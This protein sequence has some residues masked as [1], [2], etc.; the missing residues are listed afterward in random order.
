MAFICLLVMASWTQTILTTDAELISIESKH[1]QSFLIHK[2]QFRCVKRINASDWNYETHG[3]QWCPPTW[4]EVLC[5]DKAPAGQAV[6]QRCPNY[7]SGFDTDHHAERRCTENGT[8]W[9]NPSINKTWT[10]F[11]QCS[12]TRDIDLMGSM[13]GANRL[14]MLYTVGYGIS[15]GSLIIA[16][17]IMLCCRRLNSKSNTLHIN[18]FFAFILRASVSFLKGAL[19]VRQV[20]LEKD[21]REN[22]DGILEFVD[23]PH[24]ECRLLVTIF[25]YSICVSQLWIF[26]E[27]LYLHNLIYRTLSTERRGVKPYIFLGWLLPFTF[28]IPWVIV[29]Y[30]LDNHHCWTY[31]KRKELFWVIHGPLLA[32][33]VIN[34]IFFMDILRVLCTRVR[35]S[36]RHMGR[37]KYRRLAKFVLVLIPL[38]GVLYIAFHVAF[39]A[40]FKS[41]VGLTH[42][43][44]EMTYNSLQGFILALLFCFLNEEVHAE[45]KRMWYRRKSR[46][47]DSVALTKSFVVSSFKRASYINRGQVRKNGTI[48]PTEVPKNDDILTKLRTRALRIFRKQESTDEGEI[49]ELQSVGESKVAKDKN[50][51]RAES[52]A[53][54]DS[55]DRVS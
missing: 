46:R 19:F 26:M 22:E 10:N 24:W 30:T 18:L 54:A 23:G 12:P 7:I 36:A 5:W 53:C 33:V 6:L 35:A 34:F 31:S 45:I 37:T 44:I 3:G 8:W 29:R 50:D 1:H 40:R 48:V 38:F 9:F 52:S 17:I 39:P 15:L 32:T 21:V 49:N 13:T 51:N 28:L 14:K 41:E 27:G 4:D 47:G 20:G 25:M 11:S 16:V 42:L 43:Y 2:A 55:S